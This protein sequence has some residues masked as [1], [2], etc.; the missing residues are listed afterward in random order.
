MS[1]SEFSNGA[2]HTHC[3]PKSGSMLQIR[4]STLFACGLGVMIGIIIGAAGLLFAVSKW[5]VALDIGTMKLPQPITYGT[6][7]A[8]QA[9]LCVDGLAYEL[10]KSSDNDVQARL[11]KPILAYDALSNSNVDDQGWPVLKPVRQKEC[12]SLN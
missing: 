9:A 8:G 7:A 1:C 2:A 10:V 12:Q 11:I 4:I 6:T 3:F 5:P